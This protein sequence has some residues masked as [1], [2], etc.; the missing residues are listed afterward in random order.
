MPR[1]AGG[2][3]SLPEV[4]DSVIA[5]LTTHVVLFKSRGSSVGL[6]TG[7]MADGLE[8]ESRCGQEF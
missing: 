7:C 3:L 8:L 5:S 2:V 6:A 4:T 1:Q